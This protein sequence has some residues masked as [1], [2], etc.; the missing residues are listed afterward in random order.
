M[1]WSVDEEVDIATLL[2]LGAEAQRRGETDRAVELYEK[3]AS[4]LEERDA[5]LNALPLW[6]AILTMRPDRRDLRFRL[7]QCSAKLF[8][9]DRARRELQRVMEESSLAGDGRLHDR[10]AMALYGLAE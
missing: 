4:E 10:A 6:A 5:D 7:G 8:M 2:A 1:M 9:F 3:V